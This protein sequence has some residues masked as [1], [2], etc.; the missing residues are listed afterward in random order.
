V[1]VDF[2]RSNW[3][4]LA[5][6]ILANVTVSSPA[7]AGTKTMTLDDVTVGACEEIWHEAGVPL[8]FAETTADDPTPGYCVFVADANDHGLEGVHL[9]PARLVFDVSDVEG[10]DHIYMDIYVES[11]HVSARM[12]REGNQVYYHGSP[13][14][15]HQTLYLPCLGGDTVI[16]TADASYVWEIR[17]SGENLTPTEPTSFGGLKVKY[18]P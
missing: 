4:F 9:G 17:L 16:I 11:G 12:M 6:L 14:M 1:G 7:L 13:G 18:G 8:W 5:I 15:E 2:N 10:L 3:S